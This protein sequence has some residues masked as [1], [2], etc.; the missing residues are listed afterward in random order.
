[1]SHSSFRLNN[2]IEIPAV[3]F[4]VFQTPRDETIAAV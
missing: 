3:G 4:G 2:G 1:M